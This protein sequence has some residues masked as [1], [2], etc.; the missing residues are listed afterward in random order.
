MNTRSRSGLAATIALATALGVASPGAALAEAQ[1]STQLGDIEVIAT[2]SAPQW[3]DSPTA[4]TVVDTNALD[5]GRRF[6]LAEPLARVPGVFAQN[7]YN[8]A[9]GL[10][11][12]VRGF[13]ARAAF[14]VRGVR[15]LVDG[16]PLTMPDGQTELDGVD[17]ALVDRVEVV[18]GPASPLYGNAAGGV[19]ALT[20]APPQM[21]PGASIDLSAGEL[22]FKGLRGTVHGG[23]GN[24]S[25]LA[26]SNRVRVD[27]ARDHGRT[28]SDV[29]TGKLAYGSDAGRLLLN[30]NAIDI[31]SQDPGGLTREDV[32]A[33]RYQASARNRLFQAGETIRQQRLSASWEGA[34]GAHRDYRLWVYAGQ[35]EFAN[36]LPFSGGGQ[37][38]FD[39]D[40]GG[41]GAQ[42]ARHGSVVGR[43]YRWTLGLDLESQRDDRRRYDNLKGSRGPQTLDQEEQAD[44]GGVFGNARLAL[45]PRWQID[46]GL[47][48]D[49]LEL[50]VDD[51]FD[52]DG[53]QSGDRRLD[54]LSYSG[55]ITYALG[56]ADR[57][58][59][60][61]SN[62]FESPTVNELAN[63][64][65]GGFNPALEAASAVNRE[66]GLKGLHD[67]LR[68]DIAVYSIDLDDELLS[69]Q[70]PDEPGRTYYRNIGESSRDGIETSLAWQLAPAWRVDASYSYARNRF[71]R[72]SLDG[73]DYADNEIP[74]L[75]RHLGFVEL[76]W[77]PGRW[78]ARVNARAVGSFYADDANQVRVPGVVLTNLRVAYRLPLAK[79]EIT[80]YFGVDNLFDRAHFDN[81][82]I[83][84]S[85]Q[86]YFEPGPGRTI[87]AGISARL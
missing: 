59:A 72:Y 47:R 27:G 67:T 7:R 24:W 19:V 33:D 2:R 29:F 30:I 53:D 20:T 80:P 61:V 40:F 84:A 55:A 31:E 10:R 14:G 74:G 68:Y 26:A 77:R 86:R 63:P 1:Q 13:G 16:V 82:R 52:G 5:G 35:R 8:F 41:A 79:M 21:E 64:M 4:T 36:R 65:G 50:E 43:D 49:R 66:L 3:L 83:N 37:V 22:G 85:A 42:Y 44:S 73:T 54:E 70:L 62:S 78:S 18:R 58:Y 38:A 76:A 45:T 56:S 12:S 17:L 11:L 32:A 48:Y 25:G 46:A 51:R 69:Y 39:R 9:Q 28:E 81:I 6:S 71:D 23:S 15:V 75:P 57:I 87:F 34:S 60:R